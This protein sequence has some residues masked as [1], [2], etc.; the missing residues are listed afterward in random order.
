MLVKLTWRSSRKTISSGQ[1]KQFFF[2]G[3]FFDKE[4]KEDNKKGETD[5]STAVL[6]GSI[7][8]FDVVV[9]AVVAV[10]TVVVGRSERRKERN[11]TLTLWQNEEN[12]KFVKENN[13]KFG[14]H[15][16]IQMALDNLTLI[17]VDV[18]V[19]VKEKQQMKS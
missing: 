12:A 7:I 15:Q 18:I 19:V 9:A 2:L 1:N 14:F 11:G 5:M 13:S 10:V 16:I 17:L 3:I 6:N 4:E 8:A